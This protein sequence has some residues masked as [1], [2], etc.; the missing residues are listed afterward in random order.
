MFKLF[1]IG[2]LESFIIAIN[3]KFLQRSKKLLLFFS[4][5]VNVLIW[6]LVVYVIANTNLS[7]YNKYVYA[8]GFSL[9]SVTG[10]YF[11]NYLEKLA[12]F[13]GLKLKKKRKKKG[14]RK[15]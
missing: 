10:V 11:D 9:G 1:F 2:I 14:N 5:F 13:K 12:K 4:S 7:S 15:K 8:L 6:C 3:Y